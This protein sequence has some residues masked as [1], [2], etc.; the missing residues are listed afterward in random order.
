MAGR[1]EKIKEAVKDYPKEVILKDGTGVTLRPIR[2]GDEGALFDMFRHFS[3]DELWF[4]NH[5]VSDP[6]LINEWIKD[7]DLNRMI[8]IVA[9]LSDRIIANAALMMKNYGAKSHIG[10][11]RISVDPAFRVKRLGTWMLLD[12]VNLAM[13][14]GLNMLVMR[15]VQDRDASIINGVRKLGFIE[16][17]II[18]DYILDKEGGSHNLVIMVKRLPVEWDDF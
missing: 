15:L 11:I 17:T 10:K 7:L 4:L 14:V 2:S 6:Q 1:Q 18:K 13:A 3:E 9:E 16:E 5:D 8:S 12:I